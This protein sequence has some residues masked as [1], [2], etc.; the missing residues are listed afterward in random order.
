MSVPRPVV[1]GCFLLVT[2][3]VTQRQF[4]LRPDEETNNIFLYCLAE[5]ARQCGITIVLSQMMSNHHHTVLFDPEGREVEFR[6]RFHKL[7]AKAQ[8]AY[9]G[10]W[11]NLWAAE[12]PSVVVLDSIEDVLAKLTYVATNPVKDGLVE[13]VHH[14][15]GPNF[16][17]AL[18]T[19]KPMRAT[20]PR[21]FF[22]DDGKMPEEVELECE[23]PAHVPNREQL[24]DELRRRI[25]EVEDACALERQRTGRRVVGR[26]GVLRQSW[27]ESPT[28]REPR[29]GLRPRV[30]ARNTWAR[31]ARLQRNKAWEAEYRACRLAWLAG[32]PVEFPY[33]T[34]W[35]ARNA[36]VRVKPPPGAA[37]LAN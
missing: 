19:G 33:G 2:R 4:L 30:A 6:E 16:T 23:L 3:R 27:R 11:E 28:S 8:N 25:A 21:H 32:L 20:R 9:R 14:W 15:P 36:N 13:K 12:E 26:R 35:L 10:R 18:L 31:I 29:R 24:L 5:A 34:Y 1:P 17:S 22:R 7:L 37:A